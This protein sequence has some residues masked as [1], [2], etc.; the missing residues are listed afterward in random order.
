MPRRWTETLESLAENPV[1]RVALGLGL[2][3]LGLSVLRHLAAEVRPEDIAR[4]LAATPLPDILLSLAATGISFLALGGYDVVTAPLRSLPVRVAMLGGAAGYAVSNLFGV[5][6]LTGGLLRHRA[7]ARHGLDAVDVAS[8]IGAVW[9]GFWLAILAVIGL[10]LTTEFD[11]PQG[12]FGLH[13]MPARGLGVVLLA[14][15]CAAVA[16]TGRAGRQVPLG[17]WSVTLPGRGQ[18]VRVM[19]L[20][21][22]DVLG[23][24]VALYVLLPGDVTTGFAVFFVVFVVALGLGVASHAP[25]GLGVF[26]ATLVAGLG[27]AGRSD[28]LAAL[29][30]YRAIYYLLP[31]VLLF[32]PALLLMRKPRTD[33]T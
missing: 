15:V 11:M 1:T 21:L 28:V 23:A 16:L 33:P 2:A 13:G 17:H 29:L 3:V 10:I 22:A 26:E 20:A 14:G 31:F 32:I 6:W 27:A 8:M 24:S 19:A 9:F 5:S 25:G 4:D 7:Y 18:V 12:L 30:V